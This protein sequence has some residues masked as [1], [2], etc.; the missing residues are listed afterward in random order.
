MI[1]DECSSGVPTPA[2]S[3]RRAGNYA[4]VDNSDEARDTMIAEGTT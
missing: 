1:G 4:V 3:C 2:D